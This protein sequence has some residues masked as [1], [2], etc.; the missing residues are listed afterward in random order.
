ML[1]DKIQLIHVSKMSAIKAH[2]LTNTKINETGPDLPSGS[3]K[4]PRRKVARVQAMTD[5][6]QELRPAQRSEQ[7]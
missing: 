2:I 5:R 7:A 3:T 1:T 4:G 6:S